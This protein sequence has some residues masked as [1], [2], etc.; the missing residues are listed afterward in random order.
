MTETGLTL[1][2]PEDVSKRGGLQSVQEVDP[3]GGRS[4]LKE[5]LFKKRKR[6]RED[7]ERQPAGGGLN[8]HP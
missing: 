5:Q 8:P 4:L 7:G 1:T 3:S 2:Y 6:E